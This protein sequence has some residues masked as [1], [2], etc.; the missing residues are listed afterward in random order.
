MSDVSVELL[1]VDSLSGLQLASSQLPA[2]QDVE[3]FDGADVLARLRH[4]EADFAAAQS[5]AT[6]RAVRSDWSQYI[7]W[8]EQR[9][10][11]P[12]PTS[13]TQLEA[14]VRNA[15]VRG[16]KRA[17]IDRYLYTI[18]LI[19]KEAGLPRPTAHRAWRLKWRAM[20]EKELAMRGGNTTRQAA[21]LRTAD[22]DTI[23]RH[24]AATKM[25]RYAR[26]D[27]AML[28]L[29]SDTLLRESELVRVCVEHFSQTREGLWRLW[30]PFT[31]TNRSGA[32]LDYR[33]VTQD[34][35]DLINALR[36]AEGI[37]QDVL[38]RAISGRPRSAEGRIAQNGAL[39]GGMGPEEVARIFRRRALQAGLA[40]AAAVSGHSTRV[41]M[42]NDMIALG[43]SAPQI[44]DAGKWKSPQMVTLY[45][46]RSG[47]GENVVG[48]AK[49]KLRGK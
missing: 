34:T 28:S 15:I 1:V 27:A 48:D 32:E 37:T 9:A 46:R 18:D 6:M 10:V 8:C 25:T 31:K 5:P 17:T 49:A 7:R 4:W 3:T 40:N 26:R 14:Y 44:M 13:V 43:Y 39:E 22:V 19:H 20:T 23:L 30:V 2:P 47:A 45:T 42:A 12:L 33:H 29:A 11:A 16:R 35:I 21:E 24:L 41:G 36:A 38:F